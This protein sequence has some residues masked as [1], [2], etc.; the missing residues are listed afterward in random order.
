M[1]RIKLNISV[2]INWSARIY[3]KFW[4]NINKL[5][6]FP[7]ILRN[8]KHDDGIV[9]AADAKENNTYEIIGDVSAL[10]LIDLQ[11]EYA[12]L[13]GGSSVLENLLNTT[14]KNKKN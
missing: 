5:Q 1:S 8:I 12:G 2:L 4:W 10:K 13:T 9:L 6:Q 7:D 3:F 11:S 14:I